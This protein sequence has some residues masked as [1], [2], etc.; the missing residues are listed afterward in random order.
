[1]GAEH[2]VIRNGSQAS[3][4]SYVS[5]A[6]REYPGLSD[7]QVADVVCAMRGVGLDSDVR[8]VVLA[9]VRDERA[10]G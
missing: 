10:R 4:E 1:M 2:V 3:W 9:L 6:V 7:D 8:R 5:A